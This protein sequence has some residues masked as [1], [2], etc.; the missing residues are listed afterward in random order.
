[1]YQDTR[2]AWQENT[3]IGKL[4]SGSDYVYLLGEKCKKNHTFCTIKNGKDKYEHGHF[5][6]YDFITKYN[7]EN[8]DW[9]FFC[10]D[11]TYVFDNKLRSLLNNYSPKLSIVIG[12]AGI[13]NHKEKNSNYLAKYPIKFC[14][15]GAG[16]ATS[17]PVM[18]YLKAYLKVNVVYPFAP[19]GDTTFGA[20]LK[21]INLHNCIVDKGNMFSNGPPTDI[22]FSDVL[23]DDVITFH[24]CKEADFNYL[25]S[26]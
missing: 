14:G 11:D 19:G 20:W 16:W 10:D 9:I 5:K 24:W 4:P 6:Y 17:L 18:C 2:R 12:R 23:V 21:K 26:K 22:Q 13:V 25:N 15:G 8:F 3:W 1:M 7:Y